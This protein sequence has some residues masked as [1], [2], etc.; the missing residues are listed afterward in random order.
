MF[1]NVFVDDLYGII[2][3]EFKIYRIFNLIRT[4]V[5]ELYFVLCN[6]SK[7]SNRQ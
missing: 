2:H 3:L 6:I 4:N 5:K 7:Y 1:C